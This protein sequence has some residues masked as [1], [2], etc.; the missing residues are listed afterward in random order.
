MKFI[1]ILDNLIKKARETHNASITGLFVAKQE[2]EKF[3]ETKTTK[4]YFDC[5]LFPRTSELYTIDDIEEYD[6]DA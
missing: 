1:A 2:Y 6:H 4:R 5:R 3:L